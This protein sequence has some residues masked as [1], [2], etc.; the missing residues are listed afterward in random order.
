MDFFTAYWPALLAVLSAN[1][2]AAFVVYA[3]LL[4]Y[5]GQTTGAAMTESRRMVM[6][7]L[8]GTLLL[9][10]GLFVLAFLAYFVVVLLFGD[11]LGL[12]GSTTP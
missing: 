7:V 5:Q 4:R 1:L 2:I 12:L 3:G 9:C 11:V 8:K 10:I 6:T